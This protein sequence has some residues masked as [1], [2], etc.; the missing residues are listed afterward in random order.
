M[1]TWLSSVSRIARIIGISCA[2]FIP[3]SVAAQADSMSISVTPPLI[4][5]TVGPGESWASS[6]KVIN[7]NSYDVSY[8]ASVVDFKAQGEEGEGT[9][10]PLVG[11]A[12]STPNSYSLASWITLSPAPV[13]IKAGASGQIPFTVHVPADAEPGGHY[14]AILVGTQPGGVQLTGPSMKISSFVSSLVFVKIR[15]ETTESGR[16]R[17]FHTDKYVNDTP[18]ADFLLRFENTGN[19]HIQPQGDIVIYNMWG[20]K[21]GELAVNENGNFGNVLPGSTRKFTFT[22]AGDTDLLDVGRY[23]AVVTLAYGDAGKQNV[24]AVAYFW[25]VPTGPVAAV[26]GGTVVI[27]FLLFWLIRRYVRRALL[28]E[29]DRLGIGESAAAT[30]AAPVPA[31]VLSFETFMEP[32]REGVI[33]LRRTAGATSTPETTPAAP[34]SW[35]DLASKYRLFILFI[36]VIIAVIF[37]GWRYFHSVLVPARNFQITDV[38]IQ[39]DAPPAR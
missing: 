12:S 6:L 34:L 11:G 13:R 10:I 3:L 26:F 28:L 9:L 29:R 30:A 8:Y 38:S 4:Q 2:L 17:E 32:M 24:S 36:V 39:P 21:R 1:N 35:L 20:K 16:I 18:S 14:A 37:G 5:L 33:D 19:T 15:G 22:W 23:S 27:M 31:P 7:T 25:V